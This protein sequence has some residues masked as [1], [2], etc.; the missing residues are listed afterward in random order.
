MISSPCKTCKNKAL[1]K[2]RCMKTCKTIQE[3]QDRLLSSDETVLSFHVDYI[4]E[5]VAGVRS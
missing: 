3:A 5:N 2:D 4:E 1:P